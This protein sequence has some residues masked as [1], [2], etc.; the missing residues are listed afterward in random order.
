MSQ[1]ESTDRHDLFFDHSDPS[2]SFIARYNGTPE[3]LRD[4]PD[5]YHDTG[6]ISVCR[7]S[8]DTID[9]VDELRQMP[10]SEKNVGQNFLAIEAFYFTLRYAA[11]IGYSPNVGKFSDFGSRRAFIRKYIE[12]F[13][14]RLEYLC[15]QS[16][17]HM[18]NSKKEETPSKLQALQKH[19]FQWLFQR[20]SCDVEHVIEIGKER[21]PSKNHKLKLR[22]YKLED[23]SLEYIIQKVPI[24]ALRFL[25]EANKNHRKEF[26]K[27]WKDHAMQS[28]DY[29]DNYG[30]ILPCL[31]RGCYIEVRS[32]ISEH[33]NFLLD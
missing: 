21:D 30:K 27:L 6:T 9:Y 18:L 32:G 11:A 14:H 19:V 26:E 10:L 23:F 5:Q 17:F 28:R 1:L 16:Q 12:F 8:H 7:L 31:S 25:S 3:C 13:V 2:L 20:T 22:W 24:V 4:S 15:R 29:T 33:L